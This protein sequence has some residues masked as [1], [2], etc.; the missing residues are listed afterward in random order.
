MRKKWQT[1]TSVLLSHVPQHW[2]KAYLQPAK[3]IRKSASHSPGPS[4]NNVKSTWKL[5]FTVPYQKKNCLRCRRFVCLTHCKEACGRLPRY[6]VLPSPPTERYGLVTAFA[7]RQLNVRIDRGVR[8]KFQ[9]VLN[10][11]TLGQIFEKCWN[12]NWGHPAHCVS[13][14]SITLV[15][16][17][18]NRAQVSAKKWNKK[19][20][21]KIAHWQ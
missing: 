12:V 20:K 1:M 9:T 4:V 6:N 7:A 8:L 11:L 19:K 5:H 13:F 15:S 21:E 14:T 16:T 18:K 17:E 2:D 3:I 10:F